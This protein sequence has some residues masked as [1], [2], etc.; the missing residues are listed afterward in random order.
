[1]ETSPHH[2][3]ALRWEPSECFPSP[4]IGPAIP[5]TGTDN[6]V[7]LPILSSMG[8]QGAT[9]S[10]SSAPT[11]RSL[12]R[13]LKLALLAIAIVSD[14]VSLFAEALLPLEWLVDGLTALAL[15]AVLGF[16]WQLLPVIVVEAIPGLAAFPTWTLAVLALLAYGSERREG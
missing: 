2:R 7:R 1:M 9:P 3:D 16:R 11:H 8:E 10:G 15:F 12:S 5:R 6:A 13:G 14:A 4:E